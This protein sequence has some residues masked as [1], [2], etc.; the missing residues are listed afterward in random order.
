M[1]NPRPFR[2]AVHTSNAPD[3]KAW[4]EAARRYED[5]GFSTLLL[6]DAASIVAPSAIEAGA[7]KREGAVA[8]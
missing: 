5:V 4:S 1:A 3:G 2:F 6:R 8:R 7:P